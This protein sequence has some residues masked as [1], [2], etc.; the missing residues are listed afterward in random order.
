MSK[1]ITVSPDLQVWQALPKVVSTM[2]KSNKGSL[3]D[4]LVEQTGVKIPRERLLKYNN[5]CGFADSVFAPSTFLYVLSQAAQMTMLTQPDVPF[6]LPGMVHFANRIRQFRPVPVMDSVDFR[7]SFGP[8]IAH[9]KGQA[10][11]MLATASIHGEVVW[12]SL[13]VYLRKGKPGAGQPFEWPETAVAEN[14]AK[15]KWHLDSGLGIRYGKVSGDFNPIHMHPL[16]A[17]LFGMPRHII[18]GMYNKGRILA[19]LLP[20]LHSDQ[21]EIGVAFKVPVQLPA[22][23]IYRHNPSDNGFVFDVVDSEEVKPHLRGYLRK[24]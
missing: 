5:V 12:E 1:I 18:H 15:E 10:F 23:I 6:A 22:D 17:R 8:M 21:Y 9:D 20:E 3:P 4:I 7:I 16:T 11:E 14:A 24:L 2:F 19:Q 13:S